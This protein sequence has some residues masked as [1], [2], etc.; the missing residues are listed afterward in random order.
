MR[1]KPFQ[2]PVTVEAMVEGID[3]PV[4]SDLEMPDL[5]IPEDVEPYKEDLGNL[6]VDEEAP[7][8]KPAEQPSYTV[9][10]QDPVQ[11]GFCMDAMGNVYSN[12]R[13]MLPQP[14]Y[15]GSPTILPPPP[16]PTP[17]S[18]HPQQHSY[19]MSQ[20]VSPY[21]SPPHGCAA[22]MG[23][24]MMFQPGDDFGANGMYGYSGF[25]QTNH[26]H[27]QLLSVAEPAAP[28]TWKD[29][30][31]QVCV[32]VTSWQGGAAQVVKMYTAGSD[33]VRQEVLAEL[34]GD[35]WRL[36]STHGGAL[37]L[38]RM[39]IGSRGKGAIPPVL[40]TPLVTIRL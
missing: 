37:L 33:S 29:F 8:E 26:H 5:P 7:E 28:P 39:V 38:K 18:F 27:H 25:P 23:Q 15:P 17:P 35:L 30:R 3:G 16:P 32:A 22:F 34:T 36:A 1:T 4:D 14:P 2:F 21:D 13:G 11:V 40:C 6:E 19:G 20:P 10:Y 12:A 31:G 9:A 24:Q